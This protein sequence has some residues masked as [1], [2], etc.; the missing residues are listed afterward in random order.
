MFPCDK[1]GVCFQNLNGVEMYDDLNDSYGICIHFDKE[2]KSCKI[3][4]NRPEKSNVESVYKYFQWI[5]VM[6]NI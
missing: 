5:W 1:R 2:T 3:Y 4:H 6:S